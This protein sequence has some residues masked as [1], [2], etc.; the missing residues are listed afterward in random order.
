MG[1]RYLKIGFV[2]LLAL[3]FAISS[4]WVEADELS[5]LII[6][7]SAFEHNGMIPSK[8][9]C[10]GSNVNPPFHFAEI[11]GGTR[12]LALIMD[13]PDAPMGTWDHWIVW[14]ISLEYGRVDENTVPPGSVQGKNGW[15]RSEYGGPC[16]PSGTHRY[17]IKVFALDSL[18]PLEGGASK[19]DLE[20]AMGGHILSK[21]ELI[22]IYR[23][24]R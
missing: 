6:S 18:I 20:K 21:G 10:D 14:N 7:S 5:L 2:L 23:R 4:F 9:T 16:P 13:D 19:K 12:T 17:F 22:G 8:Y 24:S 11:P 3:V 15:G 1:R